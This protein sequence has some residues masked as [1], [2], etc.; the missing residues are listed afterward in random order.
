MTT[1]RQDGRP[2]AAQHAT[3]RRP[4]KTPVLQVYGSVSK[5]TMGVG[6]S[7]SD[8]GNMNKLTSD[9]AY[10]QDI[11]RVG[12]HPLGFGLY[13]FEYKAGYAALWG[14]GRRLGVMA[15]EVA[16]VLPEAVSYDGEGHRVVDYAMV[17]V[18]PAAR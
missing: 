1:H 18:S 14:R 13:L 16:A 10:K 2:A 4:Y 12:T 11:V 9:R 15:D 5:L 17:G 6:G 3:G 8:A 7:K